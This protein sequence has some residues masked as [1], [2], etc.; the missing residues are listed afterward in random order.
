MRF[1]SRTFET[2]SRRGIVVP[3]L[4]FAAVLAAAPVAAQTADDLARRQAATASEYEVISRQITL[5]EERI[6]GIED[7]IAGLKKD[8]QT[9]TAA[10]IQAA[11]TERKLSQDAV[12]IE[13][14]IEALRLQ[15]DDLKLSL[16]ERRGVL[17]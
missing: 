1:G 6:K 11:K 16:A 8:E 9:L 12:A 3:A 7:E 13:A 17:A 10:L 2:G 14:K 15:Q 5:S 4:A